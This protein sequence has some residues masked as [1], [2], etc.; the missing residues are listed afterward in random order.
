MSDSNGSEKVVKAC[1]TKSVA[2]IGG[3]TQKWI[4]PEDEEETKTGTDED[5][6]EAGMRLSEEEGEE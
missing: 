4:M 5:E 3:R 6:D 2:S 1:P